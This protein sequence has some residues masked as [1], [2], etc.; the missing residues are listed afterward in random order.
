VHD[1]HP[2]RAHLGIGAQNISHVF[3]LAA[4]DAIGL[5]HTPTRE[6]CGRTGVR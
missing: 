4:P 6:P 1:D 5:A 3:T 2:Q